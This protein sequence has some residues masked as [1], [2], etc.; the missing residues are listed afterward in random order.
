MKLIT[1]PKLS[2]I[3]IYIISILFG[4]LSK[5]FEALQ[6]KINEFNYNFN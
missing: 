1:K 2:Y 3:I 5:I 4:S 6:H